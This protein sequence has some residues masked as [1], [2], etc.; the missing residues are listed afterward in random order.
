MTEI[1]NRADE[2]TGPVLPSF[3][4]SAASLLTKLNDG[5]SLYADEWEQLE[6]IARA[7]KHC[8]PPPERP[9]L[10]FEPLRNALSVAEPRW[11][12]PGILGRGATTMLYSAPKTGKTIFHLALAKALLIGGSFLG[13]RVPKVERLWLLSEQSEHSLGPQLRM[14]TYQ[15]DEDAH[16]VA[17]AYKQ[18][19]AYTPERLA[20]ALANAYQAADLKPDVVVI[21]TLAR[22]VRLEDS[23]N[24]SETGNALAIVAQAFGVMP[25]TAAMLVHHARKGGGDG[26]TGVLGSTA[27]AG[28]P[29]ILIQ[30]RR[31]DGHQRKVTIESRLG[32]GELEDNTLLIE[33]TLPGGDYQRITG[34][35]YEALRGGV[36]DAV[37][38]GATRRSE[39]ITWLCQNGFEDVSE[40][41]ASTAIKTLLDNDPPLLVGQGNGRSRRYILAD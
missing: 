23:S 35:D 7:A 28:S 5:G 37:A 3:G 18:P 34:T 26:S 24:Y 17:Y 40:Y 21:D 19:E 27:I 2:I 41:I 16:L 32:L 14:I 38:D 31:G 29:D 13:L 39:I 15:P 36:L 12:V 10:V 9:A 33:L 1:R 30:M 22:F 8:S 25:D 6:Q 4:E 20:E 11:V